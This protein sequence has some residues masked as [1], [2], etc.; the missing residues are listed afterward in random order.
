MCKYLQMVSVFSGLWLW[1]LAFKKFARKV[2]ASCVKYTVN[3][4]KHFYGIQHKKVDFTALHSTQKL[5]LVRILVNFILF[6]SIYNV[7]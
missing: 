1:P 5:T 2:I 6:I 7:L 3:E 4:T